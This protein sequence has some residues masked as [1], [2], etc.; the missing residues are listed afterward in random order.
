MN[1]RRPTGTRLGVAAARDRAPEPLPLDT[2]VPNPGL[3][4]GKAARYRTTLLAMH[5]DAS[6][7]VDDP[8]LVFI[9]AKK[10]GITI[11][12]RKDPAGVRVWR[13]TE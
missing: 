3:R 11:T 8:N 2:H 4:F 6:F 10:L 7:V 13:V 1:A 12:T 9:E 5:G